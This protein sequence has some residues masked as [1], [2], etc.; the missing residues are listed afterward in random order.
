MLLTEEKNELTKESDAEKVKE[1]F[2]ECLQVRMNLAFGTGKITIDENFSLKAKDDVSLSLSAQNQNVSDALGIKESVSNKINLNGSLKENSDRLGSGQ[3]IT[4]EDYKNFAINGVKIDGITENTT[5][6]EMLELINKTQGANVK[7]SYMK[8]S[9][10]LILV[11]SET[12]SGRN[13]LLDGA[14]EKIFSGG[15]RKDGTDAVLTYAYN[16]I[17]EE[18]ITSSSNTFD[19]DG[20]SVTVNGTFSSENSPVTFKSSANIEKA[21]GAVEK[22]IEKYNALVETVNGAV[23]TKPSNGYKPLTEE[24]KD[25]MSEKSIENWEKKAKEGL[26]FGDSI[27]RDLSR[28]LNGFFTEFMR[29]NSDSIGYGELKTMGIEMSSD[30]HDGGK[31]KFDKKK[32]EAALKKDPDKISRLFAGDKRKGKKV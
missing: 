11:S 15:D 3:T 25:E 5:V 14:A 16:G 19:I 6:E 29:E 12:G 21:S 23:R 28:D 17:A 4:E 27:I 30:I 9:N 2:R 8:N 1:K 32:F 20:L 10:Q 31:I 26:L 13:I 24:Q 22:F 18:T 7:A